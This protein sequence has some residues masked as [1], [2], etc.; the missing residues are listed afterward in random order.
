MPHP[1][2]PPSPFLSF[3]PSSLLPP[4]PPSLRGEPEA[5]VG[6]HGKAARGEVEPPVRQPIGEKTAFPVVGED[7]ERGGLPMTRKVGGEEEAFAFELAVNEKKA[8][9]VGDEDALG[10]A[11]A[12]RGPFASGGRPPDV[13][14]PSKRRCS[15]V[16]GS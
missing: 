10:T 6:R 15:G 9:V 4:L 1:A 11:S 13:R 7:A 8:V 16:P 14:R 3:F 12:R 5:A 2:T